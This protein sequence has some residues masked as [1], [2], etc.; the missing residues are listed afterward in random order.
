M[1]SNRTIEKKDGKFV[2]I[3]TIK[4]E[5]QKTI[6]LTNGKQHVKIIEKEGFYLQ[7][8]SSEEIL[9]PVELLRQTTIIKQN[10]QTHTQAKLLYDEYDRVLGDFK[11]YVK[12]AREMI[13]ESPGKLTGTTMKYKG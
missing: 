5:I 8:T 10:R 12:K 9:T 3:T 1:E 6:N 13:N 2:V 4:N 7:I 11:P